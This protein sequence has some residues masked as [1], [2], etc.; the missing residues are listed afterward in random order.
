M[1]RDGGAQLSPEEGVGGCWRDPR[2]DRVR[3]ELMNRRPR[4]TPLPPTR[5]DPTRH[6]G[7]GQ[8]TSN[9]PPVNKHDTWVSSRGTARSRL[10]AAD[11]ITHETSAIS[12]F[13]S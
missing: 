11:K 9:L 6:T 7:T 1:G 4:C 3:F 12:T 2:N 10:L 5:Q 13:G 8:P